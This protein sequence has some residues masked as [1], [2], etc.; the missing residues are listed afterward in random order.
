[1]V[2]PAAALK[3]DDPDLRDAGRQA[4][5]EGGTA[6][7]GADHDHVDGIPADHRSGSRKTGGDVPVFVEI[8]QTGAA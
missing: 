1:M 2:D 5:G 8:G 4:P 7:P 3:A 6:E